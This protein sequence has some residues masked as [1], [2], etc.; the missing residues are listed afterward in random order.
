MKRLRIVHIS[1]V[2][3]RNLRY[4][5]EYE[6]TFQE[7]YKQIR[8][9]KP[10]LVIN[11]GDLVH[12]KTQITP[13]LVSMVGRHIREVSSIAPY[14]LILGNHDL[15]LKNTDR[16]DAISPIIEQLGDHDV[17]LWRQSGKARRFITD[18]GYVNFWVFSL[19]DQERYPAPQDWSAH[20]DDINIGLFHGS[21]AGCKTDIDWTMS[22]TEHDVSLF[23]GLDYVLMGDIHRHQTWRDG[24]VAYAGS[25]IQQNFGE[26]AGKGFLVW[27][28]YGKDRFDM[29]FEELPT[30]LRFCSVEIAENMAFSPDEV[31]EG[32]YLRVISRESFTT[33]E[34]KRI[35]ALARERFR[36][37]E[38]FVVS[39]PS[40]GSKVLGETEVLRVLDGTDDVRRP[41][42]LEGLVRSYLERRGATE[43]DVS[44]VIELDRAVRAE[45]TDRED[46]PWGSQ[47]RLNSI[48]WSNFA[49]YG[50]GNIIDFDH[51][52]GVYGIF[53][54]N[55]GGKSSIFE[56]IL[57]G[58]FDKVTKYVPKNIDLI[59][60]R[61]DQMKIVVD[62]TVDER[63]YVIERTVDRIKFGQRKKDVKE[64]GKTSLDFYSVTDGERTL[65]NGDTRPETE[66]QVRSLIGSFEDFCLTSM[67]PQLAVLGLPG[68]GDFIGCKETERKRLLYRF[69]GLDLFEERLG[70][71]K[72]SVKTLS[73]ELTRAQQ[74]IQG[75]SEQMRSEEQA[76]ISRLKQAQDELDT[77]ERASAQ[78]SE[79]RTERVAARAVV[80]ARCN[81]SSS[82]K[83][84]ARQKISLSGGIEDAEREARTIQN[85]I[86]LAKSTRDSMPHIAPEEDPTQEIR[87]VDQEISALKISLSKLQ[88]RAEAGRKKLVILGQVPCGD[89]FPQCMFLKDAIAARA[90]VTQ[91]T[92]EEASLSAILADLEEKRRSLGA[93]ESSWKVYRKY[94]ET[95]KA[96]QDRLR[97]LELRLEKNA[98]L[99][100]RLRETYAKVCA[101]W[102]DIERQE[103]DLLTLEEIDA[104]ILKI[105]RA[106]KTAAG[107]VSSARSI[108][109][110]TS[111]TLHVLQNKIEQNTAAEKK[112]HELSEKVRIANLYTQ[113]MGKD[114]MPR[115][116]LSGILPVIS[117]EVNRIVANVA[118]FTVSLEMDDEQGLDLY[119]CYPDEQVRPVGLAGGAAKFIISLAIRAALTKVGGLPRSNVFIVD[120]GFGRLDSE[121]VQA[122]QRMFQQLKE[123][124]DH[125]L[126]VSHTESLRDMVDGTIDIG[127]DSDGMAHVEHV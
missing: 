32:A 118:N 57:E 27:D 59:N 33:T 16:S 5:A 9:L 37:R 104:D 127:V 110:H 122:V 54:A 6:R 68:G 95:I 2:H 86:N 78:L 31:P 65:L 50:E 99:L 64:W 93:R 22:E 29:R 109:Q 35:M 10:D 74:L 52:R 76:M 102:E 51:A 21:L 14:R 111:T 26:S 117:R 69:L 91:V 84:V 73:G 82:P 15:N 71:V 55:D 3:I 83:D 30:P 72:E 11:T 98:S 106:I 121:N 112:V 114:G 17:E 42:V 56:A 43:D 20:P 125:V 89:A 53:A 63:D 7:L 41:E 126:I 108:V 46:S 123:M 92:Q 119:V 97:Q 58:L 115:E 94:L 19:A 39:P 79:R 105:D 120:E 101:Q 81:A 62:F 61:R 85:E 13:E 96:E 8:H 75:S 49:Q 87:T 1:D 113:I 67:S 23:E 4:H 80:A 107:E 66:R 34:Q 88:M 36:P 47:W 45:V 100:S 103:A 24:R 18:F 60:D 28:I 116:I 12:S 124:F 70:V 90:D 48:G 77:L 38:V 40:Q 44:R 25:L